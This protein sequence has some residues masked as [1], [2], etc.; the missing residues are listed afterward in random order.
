MQKIR[1]AVRK[2][3]SN[4]PEFSMEMSRELSWHFHGTSIELPGK[5]P[6]TSLE[7]STE[8]PRKFPVNS[9]EI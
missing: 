2:F 9:M 7:I 3:L 5:R 6:G 8:L 4:F 1:I